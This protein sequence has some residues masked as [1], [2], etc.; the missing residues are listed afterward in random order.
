MKTLSALITIFLASFSQYAKAGTIA[1]ETKKSLEFC[2]EMPQAKNEE[3]KILEDA[4]QK[5]LNVDQIEVQQ[6]N[7]L[8]NDVQL[9][10]LTHTS[11]PADK[12]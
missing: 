3:C 10:M 6:K 5:I 4:Y 12:M 7:Y 2:K 8:E 1:E 11:V 9:E